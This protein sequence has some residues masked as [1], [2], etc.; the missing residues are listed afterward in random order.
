MNDQSGHTQPAS[1]L[2]PID[3]MPPVEYF[4]P[5]DHEL[6]VFGYGS[7]MWKPGFEFLE[8]SQARLYGYN[9]RLCIYSFRHR[10]TPQRPGLV[11]GLDRGGSCSGIAF[12]IAGDRSAEVTET[13]WHREMSSGVYQPT[14]ATIDIGG[15]RVKAGTFVANTR[16]RQ[17]CAERD[18]VVMKKLIMQGVGE[19]GANPEYVFNTVAHLDE[20]G[21]PDRALHTFAEQLRAEIG[22][23][24]R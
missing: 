20:L 23:E 22:F 19:S 24:R 13:L 12:R 16:H 11:F 4:V 17:Y 2:P 10:G 18:P 1:D 8:K 9:R 7:L 5:K 15:R 21:V 14:M 6:W 3:P